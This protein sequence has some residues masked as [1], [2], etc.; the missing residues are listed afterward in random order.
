[1]LLA[2]GEPA[3]GLVLLAY[4]LQP[5]GRPAIVRAAH[6]PRVHCPILFVQGT[7]DPLCNLDLLRPVVQALRVPVQLTLVED[8]DHSFKVPRSRQRDERAVW[9]EIAGTVAAWIGA[10]A[11]P[12][13]E[14]GLR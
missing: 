7:R 10:T 3:A 11:G 8:G 1:M 2:E 6:L 5:A 13:P 9:Q 4:P 14:Q 12:R